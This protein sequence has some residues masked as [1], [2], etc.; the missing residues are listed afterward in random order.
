MP[1][2]AVKQQTET[3]WRTAAGLSWM[4]LCVAYVI[5]AAATYTGLYQWLAELEMRIFGSYGPTGTFIGLLIALWSPTKFIAPDTWKRPR[6]E[7]LGIGADPQAAR[8]TTRRTMLTIGIVSLLTG[9][10]ATGIAISEA[11]D[12]A[13][14]E[15]D[16]SQSTAAPSAKRLIVSGNLRIRY[17]YTVEETL[18]GNV[19]RTRYTPLTSPTWTP[20]TAVQYVLRETLPHAAS[21]EDV[22][23]SGRSGTVRIGPA[24]VFRHALPGMVRAEYERSGLRL[25]PDVIVLDENVRSANDTAWVVAIFGYLFAFV[26]M[27]LWAMTMRGQQASSTIP[28]SSASYPGTVPAGTPAGPP[29]H[30]ELCLGG[31]LMAELTFVSYETPWISVATK[32]YPGM[33]PF[34]RYFTDPQTWPGHDA[35]FNA[36]VQMVKQRGGFVLVPEG[37]AQTQSFSLVNFD[38]T[39]GDL[40]V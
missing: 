31:E 34:W 12:T 27:I 38:Q 22:P 3:K 35:T 11:S 36:M 40:R 26:T 5:Y 1:A 16:L 20:E 25:A 13:S 9:I 8:R 17:A 14:K 10:V 24:A 4:G 19:T 33:T 30:W 2:M 37:G 23:S 18:N 29:R 6:P 21:E 28:K 32:A 39:G 7:L 15:V